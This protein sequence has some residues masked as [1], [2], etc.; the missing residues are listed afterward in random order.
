VDGGEGWEEDVTSDNECYVVFYKAARAS[1]RTCEQQH[2]ASRRIT[3]QIAPDRH[4]KDICA[5]IVVQ[6]NTRLWHRSAALARRRPLQHLCSNSFE[7][8]GWSPESQ[9]VLLNP[10]VFLNPC[11]FCDEM[12]I[13]DPDDP[14][15]DDPAFLQRLASYISTCAGVNSNEVFTTKTE[16]LA[17]GVVQMFLR[18][19]YNSERW[20]KMTRALIGHELGHVYYR[21]VAEPVIPKLAADAGVWVRTR[22][23]FH[24]AIRS[25]VRFF[26]KKLR[27]NSRRTERQADL[28]MIE[29]LGKDGL[30]GAAAGFNL[31]KRCFK[32]LRNDPNAS[33]ITRLG[34][35]MMISSSGNFRLFN[36]THRSFDARLKAM[37]RHLETKG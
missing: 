2:S 3:A 34:Y 4:R 28:F 29:K 13:K 15:L 23:A 35:K 24:F 25:I 22:H 31:A 26:D 19:K 32:D 17:K 1:G 9:Y 37:Q 18:A 11:Q 33:W 14:R 30:E 20:Q 6:Q 36:F 5:Q 10:L 21:H 8:Y 27:F 7:G 12:N 16:K